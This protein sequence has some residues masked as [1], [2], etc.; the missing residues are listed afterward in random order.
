[1]T[2]TY[3]AWIGYATATSFVR[4][5][6]KDSTVFKGISRCDSQFNDYYHKALNN[7]D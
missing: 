3:L 1:M 7:K 2:I 4:H 6:I 5:C